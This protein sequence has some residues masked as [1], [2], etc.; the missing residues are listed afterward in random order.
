MS[1]FLNFAGF[2]D[3][4]MI[5]LFVLTV[6][7]GTSV[8]MLEA[9][10]SKRFKALEELS[11][12]TNELGRVKSE[13]RT[14]KENEATLTS[15]KVTALTRAENAE[16]RVRQLED[17]VKVLE[18]SEAE[19]KRNLRV[20][21]ERIVELEDSL[22]KALEMRAEASTDPDARIANLQAALNQSKRD[23]KEAAEAALDMYK[24]GFQC[25]LL[26]VL[27]VHPSL[28]LNPLIVNADHEVDGTSIV[29]VDPVT[30]QKTVVFPTSDV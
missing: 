12:K 10:K 13:L 17:Q 27:L 16:A 5:F 8:E 30:E 29:K 4:F 25:A 6:F 26:Q 15:L 20:S 19:A 7:L 28:P 2:V 22:K 23:A 1:F 9:E 18:E 24:E 11:T 21:E 14:L 3:L